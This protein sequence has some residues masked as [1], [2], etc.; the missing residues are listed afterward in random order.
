M[1]SKSRL[2]YKPLPLDDPKQRRPDITRAK[3]LLGWEPRV[4][5]EEGLLKTVDYFRS[6][7]D[8]VTAGLGST[9]RL[10]GPGRATGKAV[11]VPFAFRPLACLGAYLDDVCH[12]IMLSELIRATGTRGAKT[13]SRH[14]ARFPAGSTSVWLTGLAI[15]LVPPSP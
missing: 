10:A 9:N 15:R 6:K 4:G 1:G 7:L 13:G 11:S 8:L 14:C 3:T 5:L 12:T 2:V